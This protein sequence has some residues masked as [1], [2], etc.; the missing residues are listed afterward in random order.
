M[1]KIWGELKKIEA[2]S[3]QI[4]GETQ[5]TAK[6]MSALAQQGAEKLLANSGTY[7]EEESQQL[8]KST[9]QEANRNR[10]ELLKANQVSANKLEVQAEKHMESAVAKIVKTVIGET[11]P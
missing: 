10:D 7:A 8:Y 1:E 5:D 11:Q 6:K 4:K 2:Q 3:E 9:T